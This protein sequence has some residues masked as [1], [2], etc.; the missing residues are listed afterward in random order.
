PA[1][2]LTRIALTI[3]S[4]PRA[5]DHAPS[6]RNVTRMTRH[7]CMHGRT[8]QKIGTSGDLFPALA[9]LSGWR[10][11]AWESV[12]SAT[13]FAKFAQRGGRTNPDEY[14]MSIALICA[15]HA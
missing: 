10:H 13:C 12:G 4:P 8:T 5:G 7:G 3:G 14:W 15:S 1:A 11:A 2:R 6:D 9:T